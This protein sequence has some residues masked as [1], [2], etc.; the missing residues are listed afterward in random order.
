MKEFGVPEYRELKTSTRTVMV[1][2]NIIMDLDKVFQNLPIT[3]IDIPSLTKKNKNIDKKKLKAPYGAII[4]VQKGIQY[5]G[6]D[7]RKRKKHWC[8]ASCRETINRGSKVVDISTVV[9]VPS[10]IEGTDIYEIKYFCTKCERYYTIRELKK[11]VN[12]LNQVTVVL[13]IGDIILNIMMFKDNFKIAGCKKGDDAV[14]AMMIL[15]QDYISKISSKTGAWTK[16][17]DFKTEQPRFIFRLVMRN[18]DFKLDFYIDREKL[19][20]LMNR[21][22]YSDKIYMSQCETTGNTNVNIKMYTQEPVDYQH[23]CLV[24]PR[25]KEAYFIK[26]DDN[27]YMTKKPGKKEYATFLVFSSSKIILSGRY[28]DDMKDMYEFFVK[29]VMKHR[30]LIEEKIEKPKFDLM[31]HLDKIDGK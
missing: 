26:V 25:G 16:K 6:I 22:Q 18:A 1:Y 15:W 23:D 19:N 2:S 11:I 28:E 9:E 20:E 5:R 8:A 29:E 21:S 17:L 13:S 27:P 14:E 7:L 3:E 12:F 4:S 24:M 10:Q 30:D 31:T